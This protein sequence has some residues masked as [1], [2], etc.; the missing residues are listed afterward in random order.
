[1]LEN[2]TK[3]MK[4]VPKGWKVVADTDVLPSMAQATRLV[5]GAAAVMANGGFVA[6]AGTLTMCMA[7]R[8]HSVPVMLLIC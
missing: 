5:V 6:P 4:S 8:R 2:V 7:A 3:E 1:M